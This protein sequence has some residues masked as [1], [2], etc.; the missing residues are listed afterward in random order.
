MSPRRP[1]RQSPHRRRVRLVVRVVA[2]DVD[3][4]LD[5][6]PLDAG[7]AAAR[8]GGWLAGLD[9]GQGWLGEEGTGCFDLGAR[10]SILFAL[11]CSAMG[12]RGEKR[13]VSYHLAQFAILLPYLLGEPVCHAVERVLD[14]PPERF[15]LL[16]P[17]GGRCLFCWAGRG[18][19]LF[20]MAVT[21]HI[22]SCTR[23]RWPGRRH[24]RARLDAHM[25]ELAR[26]REG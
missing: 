24:C 6:L 9:A 7:A 3:G 12:W 20:S 22:H 15:H 14:P 18:C 8:W 25:R 16:L 13:G 17:V 21:G 19:V 1:H 4:C 10:V 2:G 23:S 11:V 26:G 5:E